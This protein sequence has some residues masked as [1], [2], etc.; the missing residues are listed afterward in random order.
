MGIYSMC[1]PVT[2]M[3]ATTSVFSVSVI[4]RV[5][6][7]RSNWHS[8]SLCSVSAAS[9]EFIWPGYA[10]DVA[11]VAAVAATT[12]AQLT[13]QLTALS[14]YNS[15]RLTGL[16]SDSDNCGRERGRKY[17]HQS[18]TVN[19]RLCYPD[20]M[21]PHQEWSC[22]YFLYIPP[23]WSDVCCRASSRALKSKEWAL[24]MFLIY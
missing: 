24:M 16:W 9:P 4:Y 8:D 7:K 17:S 15:H 20:G 12:T 23:L 13:A 10:W 11:F 2:S 19:R 21:P 22:M 5:R 18:L 6:R 1:V 3:F 14:S